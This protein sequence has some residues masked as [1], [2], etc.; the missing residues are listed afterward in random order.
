MLRF[1][2]KNGKRLYGEVHRKNG[3]RLVRPLMISPPLGGAVCQAFPWYVHMHM[4]VYLCVHVYVHVCGKNKN[5][6]GSDSD[7]EQWHVRSYGGSAR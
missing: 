1:T 2:Q 5:V 3:T 7:R 6:G 4:C